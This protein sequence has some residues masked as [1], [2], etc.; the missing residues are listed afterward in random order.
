MF[1]RDEILELGK[2]YTFDVS[3]RDE[4]KL[5]AGKL[6]LSPSKCTLRVMGERR[7]SLDFSQSEKIECSSFHMSFLLYDLTI[8]Y[9]SSQCLRAAIDDDCSGTVNLAT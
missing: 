7:P 3:V 2:P 6:T 4:N 1:D 5:F 8:H 9:Q